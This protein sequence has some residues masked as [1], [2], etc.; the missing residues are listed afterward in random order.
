ML[1]TKTTT[2]HK[3][4]FVNDM[5]PEN[6]VNYKPQETFSQ[7]LMTYEVIR[8]KVQTDFR[9]RH[10][11]EVAEGKKPGGKKQNLNFLFRNKLYINYM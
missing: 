6:K 4:I 1:K 3:P 10:A 11:P 5:T 9:P 7:S 2:K 8:D